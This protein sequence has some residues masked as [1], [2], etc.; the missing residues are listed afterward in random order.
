MD[1]AFLLTLESSHLTIT[2]SSSRRWN[3]AVALTELA[4]GR[5]GL[6]PWRSRVNCELFNAVQF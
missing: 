6:R 4:Q 2:D 5:V 1:S 3:Y